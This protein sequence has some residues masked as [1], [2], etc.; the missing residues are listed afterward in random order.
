M[1]FVRELRVL[2]F[3]KCVAKPLISFFCWKYE[4]SVYLV[5]SFTLGYLL[6]SSHDI[7]DA[8]YTILCYVVR[9]KEENKDNKLFV[10]LSSSRGR[11]GRCLEW[12]SWRIPALALYLFG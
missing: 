9:V 4:E 2:E 8:G 12:V 5:E 1:T 7:L 6:W 10:C 3:P 11:R